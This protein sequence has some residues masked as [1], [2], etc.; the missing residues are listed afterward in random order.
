M[1]SD[2]RKESRLATH[3]RDDLGDRSVAGRIARLLVGPEGSPIETA[4]LWWSGRPDFSPVAVPQE[5]RSRWLREFRA[6]DRAV[7]ADL[8][9]PVSS[10]SPTCSPSPRVGA[11]RKDG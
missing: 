5:I 8:R 6:A 1:R 9:E 10:I 7:A 2:A 3:L 11:H 4:L